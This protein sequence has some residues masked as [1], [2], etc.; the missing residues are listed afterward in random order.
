MNIQ[1][2]EWW[3]GLASN[4]SGQGR[5]ARS[6]EYGEEL[7]VCKIPGIIFKAEELST[8]QEDLCFMKLVT[9]CGYI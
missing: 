5:V 6:C 8:F 2:I 7:C 1:E 9:S 4:G 3:R